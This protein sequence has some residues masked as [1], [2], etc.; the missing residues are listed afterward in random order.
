MGSIEKI[1][2]ISRVEY[3]DHTY[4]LETWYKLNQYQ[5][6]FLTKFVNDMTNIVPE[7]WLMSYSYFQIAVIKNI[8]RSNEYSND[9]LELLNDIRNDYLSHQTVDVELNS[10]GKQ[11]C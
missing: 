2:I 10:Y 9:T 6:A 5:E 11:R 3:H 1:P 8:L 4:K 7:K